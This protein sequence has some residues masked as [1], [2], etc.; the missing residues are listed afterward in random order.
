M[1]RKYGFD[2]LRIVSM[3]FIVTLH[4]LGVGGAFYNIYDG[5]LPTNAANYIIAS[6][7][8]AL[9]IVGVNCFVLISGYFLSRGKY[10]AKKI[11][12]LWCNVIF[13]SLIFFALKCIKGG[14]DVSNFIRSFF[15]IT[16]STYWFITVYI[17][18]YLLSP[19]INK[20]CDTLSE[21][22]FRRLIT[23][24]V[25]I[26][27]VWKSV[28]PI[29]ETIDTR[30]GYSLTWFIVLYLIGAYARHYSVNLFKK[31]S[32]N[33]LSYLGLALLS[34][35]IKNIAILA[36]NKVPFLAEGQNLFYHYDSILVLLSSVFLF[37]FFSRV[38][39]QSASL[40]KFLTFLAPSVFSVYIIHE[41]FLW[42]DF[43]WNSVIKANGYINSS[44]FAIHMVISV[45]I[46]FITCIA[47]DQARLLCNRMVRGLVR[48][49]LEDKNEQTR[50][51]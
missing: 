43:L 7:F 40:I 38:E 41:N 5:Y 22:E 4:Y 25:I 27:S 34:A 39:I 6:I 8:E 18:L 16:M 11:T 12:S 29:A 13:Y 2:L 36:S 50:K 32:F 44:F 42:R 51:Q 48:E 49:K 30:K 35:S 15:P 3:L 23:I 37:V 46:V 10:K 28:I 17:A 14:F 24:L 45:L 47:I 21:R 26:F 9:S 19:F 1:E 20:L 33:F 31:N